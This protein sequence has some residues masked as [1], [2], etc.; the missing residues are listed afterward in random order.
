MWDVTPSMVNSR[1]PGQCKQRNLA[2]CVDRTEDMLAIAF[3][4][5]V[6]AFVGFR[7]SGT[8]TVYEGRPMP[9]IG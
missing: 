6:L 8:V 5:A 4:D 1:F 3:L 2:P 9:G 7:G